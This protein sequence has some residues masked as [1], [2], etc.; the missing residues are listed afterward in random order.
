MSRTDILCVGKL[1]E[2]Y[3]SDAVSEYE[4]RL[5]A[6]TD[7]RIIEVKDEKTGEKASPAE[8]AAILA[9]EAA[10]LRPYLEPRS[11][12]IVLAIE[13]K[14][15]SSEDFADYLEKKNSGG[16]SHIQFIIG[17]SLGLDAGLKKGAELLS[18]SRM[19]FPHQLMRVILLEQLYRSYRIRKGEPYHK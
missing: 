11:L 8:E 2:R 18:F 13:G 12:R 10:R 5:S 9:A 15:Y 16:I 17:G 14:Q 6:Y 4:K 3:L 7:L 1:K 19:T